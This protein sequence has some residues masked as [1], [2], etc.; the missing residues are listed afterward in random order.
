MSESVE[1]IL[2]CPKGLE[3]L[4]AQ[5]AGGLGLAL[6]AVP[7]IIAVVLGMLYFEFQHVPRLQPALAG[8]AAA[9]AGMTIGMGI[10]MLMRRPGNIFELLCVIAAFLLIGVM[11]VPLVLSLLILVPCAV[12]LAKGDAK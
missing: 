9:A 12:W 8:M 7:L 1:L 3:A 2:T 11:R 5:E 10:K 4:L 6:L